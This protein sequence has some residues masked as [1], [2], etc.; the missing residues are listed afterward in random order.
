MPRISKG[1]GKLTPDTFNR[2]AAATE[3]VERA[4]PGSYTPRT[5]SS[6]TFLAQL[7]SSESVGQY[8][9]EEDEDN[10]ETYRYVW[11]YSWKEVYLTWQTLVSESD[12]PSNVYKVQAVTLSGGRT[13][14]QQAGKANTGAWNIIEL[15]NLGFP[16]EDATM[17]PGI[18]LPDDGS[19]YPLAVGSSASL[20]PVLPQVVVM[21]TQPIP[22]PGEDEATVFYWFTQ[23]NPISCEIDED[24]FRADSLDIIIDLGSIASPLHST[25]DFGEL[26]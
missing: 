9:N 3:A 22:S 26:I 2:I 25:L 21:H 17:G 5:G 18:N 11:K 7:T 10:V 12:D 24:P 19:I 15:K 23:D 4:G 6:R 20:T 8:F 16:P 14:S 13:G 1:L